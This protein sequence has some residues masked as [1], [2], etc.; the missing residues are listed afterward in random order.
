MSK[1]NWTKTIMN[2]LGWTTTTSVPTHGEVDAA[3][4]AMAA[5]YPKAKTELEQTRTTLHD[6]IDNPAKF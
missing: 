4:N 2:Q 5:K 6:S 1:I 3:C